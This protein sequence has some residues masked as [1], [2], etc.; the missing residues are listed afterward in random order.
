M[1]NSK[2]IGHVKYGLSAGSKIFTGIATIQGYTLL[3]GH[4]TGDIR[5]ENH[6]NALLWTTVVFAIVMAFDRASRRYKDKKSEGKS[7]E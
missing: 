3:I 6:I 7:V 4:L 5:A 2:L 1:A